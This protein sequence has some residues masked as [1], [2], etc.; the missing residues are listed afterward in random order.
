MVRYLGS[1]TT[2]HHQL[3]PT[4]NHPVL[5]DHFHE[6]LRFTGSETADELHHVP[7]SQGMRDAL[8][9]V[10]AHFIH[11]FDKFHLQRIA[12]LLLRQLALKWTNQNN[13]IRQKK[14]KKDSQRSRTVQIY[15][16]IP[17]HTW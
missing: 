9:E 7:V 16:V 8:V 6:V 4:D 1:E 15:I 2:N 5:L 12:E 11:P 10:H 14:T 13:L 3:I 17:T